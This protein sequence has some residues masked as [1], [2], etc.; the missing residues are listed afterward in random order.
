MRIAPFANEDDKIAFQE[1][2]ELELAAAMGGR[3]RVDIVPGRFGWYARGMRLCDNPD[4]NR[5]QAKGSK[6]CSECGRG[7]HAD[8]PRPL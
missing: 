3:W 1:A 8:N 6:Y 5:P 7:S 4:C 2:K